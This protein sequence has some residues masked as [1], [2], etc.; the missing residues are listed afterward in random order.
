[1]ADPH[2][3]AV[4]VRTFEQYYSGEELNIA[5]LDVTS[6]VEQLVEKYLQS[7]RRNEELQQALGEQRLLNQMDQDF[8]ARH[9]NP[10]P[11]PNPNPN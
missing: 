1:M 7:K 9:A 6:T 5:N 3:I 4:R 11:N 8:Y 10:N 2:I